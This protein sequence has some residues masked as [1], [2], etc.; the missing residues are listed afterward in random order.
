MQSSSLFM[1]LKEHLIPNAMTELNGE[2]FPKPYGGD[3]KRWKKY[4][5]KVKCVQI[6]RLVPKPAAGVHPLFG[7]VPL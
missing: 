1:D 4:S 7:V 3:F 2:V 5:N 6:F